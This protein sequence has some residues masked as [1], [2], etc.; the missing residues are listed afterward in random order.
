[1]FGLKCITRKGAMGRKSKKPNY[2]AEKLQTEMIDIC[3]KLCS[4]EDINKQGSSSMSLRSAANELGISVSKVVKLLITGGYYNSGICRKINELYEE[5]KT[6]PEIQE[7]LEV[8]RATL[9]SYLPYKKGIYNAKDLSLNAERIRVYR[10]RCRCI[11]E[12]SEK[13][14]E[15]VLWEAA[16]LFQNYPFHTASGLPFSYVLKKGRD[17]TLNKE[18]IVS[19]RKE[20]K[21]LAWSS[22]ILAFGKAL[23]LK[24]QVVERPKALGDIRGISYIYPMLYRFGIIEVP[25]ET[26]KKMQVRGRRER[27]G[28]GK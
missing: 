23:E 2:D 7:M 8:S 25:E 22:M 20:S 10:E 4:G 11:E 16:V 24:G 5:R 15:V 18:L 26:E 21:T 14:S 12:L 19:R 9:Q 3:K 1:M 17:G 27:N 28:I 13:R 6:V